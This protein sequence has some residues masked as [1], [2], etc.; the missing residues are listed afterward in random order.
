M[1][2]LFV[3]YD[4]EGAQNPIPMGTCYV[5]G[6]LK[7]NGYEDIHYWSQDIYH[8]PEEHL[9]EYIS[10]NNFD[11]VGLGFTA[12]YFQYKK[13]VSIC[14]AIN[15]AKNKPFLVLGGHGPTPLPEFFIKV[16]GADAVVMGEGETPFLNLIKALENKTPLHNVKGIAFVKNGNDCIVNER[17]TPIKNLDT[18]PH[19]YYEPLPMEYY[20]NAKVFQ[21]KPTDRMI[22]MIT[23][24]G[25]NYKCNFCQRLEKGIRFRSVGSIIDELKKYVRDYRI[26]Y[27]VFWDELF[28]FSEKRVAELTEGILRENLKIN[29]WCTGRLNIVNR[30]IL[31]MLKKSGCS[32]I[33]Y[34]IEQFDNNS[35]QKMNK[36]QTEEEIIR[37]IELTQK[38]GIRIGFNIIFGNLGDTMESLRKSMDLLKKYNDFGQLRVIRPVT[39]YPGS[40]LYDFAIVK[41]FLTGPEDFYNKHKNVESLTVNFTDI[42]EEE[43]YKLMFEANE[44]VIE[45]YY[46]HF[47]EEAIK[48]FYDVYFK[49]GLD[50][51]GARHI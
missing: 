43:F 51:R 6:Y 30:E 46:N 40:P 44:E 32:Y 2:T 19:P 13:I 39:P 20:L 50:F 18:I 25:C 23:S 41:G 42:P 11:V 7:K 29:Y 36:K 49:G 31:K 1:K 4:N 14:Q 37:G 22:N 34:G 3:M 35:L 48:N 21:M 28:M 15:K 10:D 45:D 27:V 12:G 9:T 5:A 24:R 16:T 33:D 38:E 8:Y 26:T 47:K 17:E